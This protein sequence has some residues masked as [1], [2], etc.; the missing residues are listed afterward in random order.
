MLTPSPPSLPARV[1]NRCP[2]VG[3]GTCANGQRIG[4]ESD[5]CG[6]CAEFSADSGDSRES[7]QRRCV[8]RR[9]GDVLL[10]RKSG[11]PE[12]TDLERVS[13][14]GPRI[15]HLRNLFVIE[16]GARS[17]SRTGMVGLV[18]PSR[19]VEVADGESSV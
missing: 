12:D 8:K 14:G 3:P 9:R 11:S 5:R 7:A 2:A 15:K 13:L 19:A 10:D 17:R 4:D 1:L 16:S 18:K 6:K